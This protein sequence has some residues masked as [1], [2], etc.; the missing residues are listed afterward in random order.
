[1]TSHTR[2]KTTPKPILF[3][4]FAGSR[5]PPRIFSERILERF[6]RVTGALA[7]DGFHAELVHFLRRQVRYAALS[8]SVDLAYRLPFFCGDE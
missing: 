5:L 8:V 7:V 1:M 2:S 3:F 6:Q 4:N